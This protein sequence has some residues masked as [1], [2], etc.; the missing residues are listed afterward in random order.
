M[1]GLHMHYVTDFREGRYEQHATS[2]L[3]SLILSLICNTNMAVAGTCK[4][5]AT[6]IS[7]NV[8]HRTMCI[9]KAFEKYKTLKSILVRNGKT[10]IR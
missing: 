1:S 5:R 3:H 2:E 8:E 6:Q 7:V 4:L 9:Y 10:I